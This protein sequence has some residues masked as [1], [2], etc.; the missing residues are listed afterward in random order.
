ME[1]I[2]SE[3][4]GVLILTLFL[5]GGPTLV[6]LLWL[7]RFCG[8]ALFL[9]FLSCLQA[10]IFVLIF[11]G[12]FLDAMTKTVLGFFKPGFELSIGLMNLSN[13]LVSCVEWV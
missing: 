4:L 7:F 1:V 12:T 9:C 6:L 11:C 5:I 8:G 10:P 2:S 13:Y 3:A